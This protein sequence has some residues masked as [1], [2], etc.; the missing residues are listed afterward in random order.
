[1][2]TPRTTAVIVT[3]NSRQTIGRA[4]DELRRAHEAGVMNV[5]VVDNASAD[6]T[7]ALVREQ[8]PFVTVVDSGGNLGFARG[9]NL[10]FESVTT[11]YFMLVNPDAVVPT[12]AV[13]T[14]EAFMDA[15]PAAGLCAPSIEEADG[16]LQHAGSLPT[17]WRIVRAAAGG[18]AAH[19]GRRIIEPDA[20]PFQT[21]WLCGA[22]LMI[23][24][25]TFK[26]INGFDPR[27]F[28]YFDETDL[29]RRAAAAG[30]ELWA[31]GE[32]RAR[33][34]GGHSAKESDKALFSNCIMEYYFQ[35][36]F[37]YMCKFHGYAAAAMAELGEVALLWLRSAAR[38]CMGRPD[39]GFRQ[40]WAGP[41]LKLP[42][43]VS[44]TP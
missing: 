16:S 37:Y 14:L 42:K 38:R 34:I 15:H 31:V 20:P 33:H 11:P 43:P 23:R 6:G 1:M 2:S 18:R 35:S 27:Y 12:E 29:C 22:L 21:D 19:P 41:I 44:E 28:L 10:G 36:R 40:R 3:Y 7:A 39:S 4:L 17:P 8:Y 24:S 32:A 25:A 9:C 13:R 26:Q 5:V 30:A